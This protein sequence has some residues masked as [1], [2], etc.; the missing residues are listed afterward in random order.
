MIIVVTFIVKEI[1]VARTILSFRILRLL[2]RHK[3][4]WQLSDRII[5]GDIRPA[6]RRKRQLNQL[7]KT[8]ARRERSNPEPRTP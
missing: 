6:K 5:R 4:L 3:D 7:A 2:R 8:T 1:S